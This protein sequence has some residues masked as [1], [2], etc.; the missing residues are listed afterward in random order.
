VC[1]GRLSCAHAGDTGV[2]LP[3]PCHGNW[4]PTWGN[5]AHWLWTGKTFRLSRRVIH[6]HYPQG[7][8]PRLWKTVA[9]LAP[10]MWKKKRPWSHLTLPG[11]SSCQRPP[12]GGAWG[13]G[14]YPRDN[15]AGYPSRVCSILGAASTWGSIPGASPGID[16]IAEAI[17][18]LETDLRAESTALEMSARVAAIWLMVTALDPELSRLISRYTAPGNPADGTD[19]LRAGPAGISERPTPLAGTVPLPGRRHCPRRDATGSVTVSLP[20][21]ITERSTVTGR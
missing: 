14:L 3:C 19:S 6:R 8:R 15:R 21:I 1:D 9:A 10:R 16:R 7:S 12:R 20:A 11:A 13:V 18:Q 4:L 17:D 2:D 5:G